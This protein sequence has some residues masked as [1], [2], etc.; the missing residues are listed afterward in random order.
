MNT[1]MLRV[2]AH[3]V[4]VH[5]AANQSDHMQIEEWLEGK[6]RNVRALL[7][8]L[9]TVLWEG[10]K[11]TPVSF[12]DVCSLA[13]SSLDPR[14]CCTC[15]HF[16]LFCALLLGGAL[17]PF[18]HCVSHRQLMEAH[19]LKKAYQRVRHLA[20][21]SL[22]YIDISLCRTIHLRPVPHSFTHRPLIHSH[23]TGVSAGSPGPCGDGQSQPSPGPRGFHQALCRPQG[24]RGGRGQAALDLQ[25]EGL[26]DRAKECW[27][28]AKECGAGQC[29]QCCTRQ[30]RLWTSGEQYVVQ[31]A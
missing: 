10:A 7:S 22:R 16:Y 25:G 19:T 21:L 3:G 27:A 9:H 29:L 17:S 28:W 11:W 8:S 14:T 6:E 30:G 2:S 4:A 24:P 18:H 13:M 23:P 20:L 12:G 31:V 1:S 26:R 15:W 5:H